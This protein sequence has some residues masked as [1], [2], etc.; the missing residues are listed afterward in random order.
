M[1]WQIS[2]LLT[3][4]ICA[5]GSIELSPEFEGRPPRPKDWPIQIY[6]DPNMP[7][8]MRREIPDPKPQSELP[9]S[10]LSVGEI[11]MVMSEFET[12]RGFFVRLKELNSE[13]GADAALAV[14][15]GRQVVAGGVAFSPTFKVRVYEY[16]Q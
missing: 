15:Q 9:S 1:R 3:L 2:S 14:W 16:P 8:D 5:C 10:A 11:D 13:V 6:Y 4:I 7:M 12:K